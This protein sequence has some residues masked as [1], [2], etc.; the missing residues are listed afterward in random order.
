MYHA[1]GTLF[2]H[3]FG[4]AAMRDVFHETRYIE[5]F[6]ET[7]AALAR[8][9]AHVGLIP[10][11]AA[12]AITE[13]AT[14]DGIDLDEVDERIAEI[15]LFTVAIITAWKDHVGEY[16]EYIHWGA[17]SQDIADTAFMLTV[18]EGYELL[19]ADLYAVRDAIAEIATAHADTPTIGRT[20]HVHALP[21]TFGLRAASW[22]DEL[23]RG[24]E[25]M[26]QLAP[27]LFSIQLFGAVG[28]LASLGEPGLEVQERFAEE[29]GL[30]VP[31][32]AWFSAR[33]RFAELLSTMAHVGGTLARAAREV[34]VLNREETNEV[35]EPIPEDVIGSSTMPHKRNPV[36]SGRT[37]GLAALLRGHAHTMSVFQ[38]GF[39]ERDAGL[40]YGEYAIIPEAFLYLSAILR[41]SRE[42]MEGLIVNEEEMAE[43]LRLH[44]QLVTSEA[45]MMALARDV[46]RQTA[47][48]IVHEHATATAEGDRSFRESLLGD[49][50]VTDVLSPE[51]IESL[52]DPEEYVGCSATLVDRAI[53]K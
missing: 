21:M 10:E 4:T 49:D 28:T 47:H 42:T 30:R 5:A 32:V 44:G 48:E 20:N 43:N 19:M 45:V 53:E 41:N 52:T 14:L 31:D 18:R 25:R 13:K 7:E 3:V 51:E 37:V 34:L 11:A 24:I 39:D 33:D 23:D 1:T 2:K 40:W 9:Q 16:G 17:T 6:I 15:D 36:D 26:E 35:N 38:E 22:V 46:G 12:A 29:V 8:A 50:R 27:R